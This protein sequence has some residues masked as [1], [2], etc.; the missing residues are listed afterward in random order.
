MSK[1][2]V[3]ARAM[4]P[5]DGRRPWIYFSNGINFNEIRVKLIFFASINHFCLIVVASPICKYKFWLCIFIIAFVSLRIS[6]TYLCKLYFFFSSFISYSKWTMMNFFRSAP[7]DADKSIESVK[8]SRWFCYWCETMAQGIQT[9][10][11]AIRYIALK[12][13]RKLLSDGSYRWAHA[14]DVVDI[15]VVIVVKMW[16]G[17]KWIEWHCRQLLS[18]AMNRLSPSPTHNQYVSIDW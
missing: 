10:I 8:R 4:Q 17:N 2:N 18:N 13:G 6:L 9:Y 5:C 3:C 14:V 16:Y 15:A 1:C 11:N 7:E 12:I